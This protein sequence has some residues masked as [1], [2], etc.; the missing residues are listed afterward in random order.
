MTSRSRGESSDTERARLAEELEASGHGG[1]A[2]DL[3]SAD[4]LDVVDVAFQIAD[5]VEEAC[6]DLNFAAVPELAARIREWA[7]T[8]ERVDPSVARRAKM[9]VTVYR[10]GDHVFVDLSSGDI[11]DLSR[12]GDTKVTL[13]LDGEPKV[14]FERLDS[15]GGDGG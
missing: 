2:F 10:D 13:M 9:P 6:G 4:D 12:D 15:P 14:N 7:K 5:H 1:C 3:N 11:L 8:L